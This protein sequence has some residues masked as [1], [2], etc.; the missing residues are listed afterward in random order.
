MGFVFYSEG[1]GGFSGNGEGLR[2]DSKESGLVTGEFEG[3]RFEALV[4]DDD[5]FYTLSVLLYKPQIYKWIKHNL[6]L[7]GVRINR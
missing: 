3:S 1:R 2:L 7:L 6:R 4:L 5:L